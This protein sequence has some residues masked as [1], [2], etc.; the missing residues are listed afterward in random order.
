MATNNFGF[1]PKKYRQPDYEREVFC[2][3]NAFY[4]AEN[5][6]LFIV[7]AMPHYLCSEKWGARI[8]HFEILWQDKNC[9]HM[10]RSGVKTMKETMAIVERLLEK[11]SLPKEEENPVVDLKDFIKDRFV[12]EER[13]KALRQ[14]LT[15]AYTTGNKKD[16]CDAAKLAQKYVDEGGDFPVSHWKYDDSIEDYTGSNP[17]MLA[18]KYLVRLLHDRTMDD[19]EDKVYIATGLPKSM[20]MTASE[21]IQIIELHEQFKE[22]D[23]QQSQRKRIIN[24]TQLSLNF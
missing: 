14:V 11:N 12:N 5:G 3:A 16:I 17:D 22:L 10:I 19:D 20:R 7:A 2:R 23:G 24:A 1:I 8:D 6:K 18:E 21:E 9:R 13:A 4:K 15:Y